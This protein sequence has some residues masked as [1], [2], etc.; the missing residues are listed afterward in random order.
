VCACVHG[1]VLSVCEHSFSRVLAH[2]FRKG[3]MSD[4]I[5]NYASPIL[6]SPC[7]QFH[8]PLD[9]RTGPPASIDRQKFG[10]VSGLNEG[11]EFHVQVVYHGA[12]LWEYSQV[13]V[14][15]RAVDLGGPL[16]RTIGTRRSRYSGA[17]HPAMALP[18]LDWPLCAC[19]ERWF[20][21]AESR[22]N[23]LMFC[24]DGI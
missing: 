22:S 13:T 9:C 8:S 20:E 1:Y 18:T 11:P 12:G 10:G 16:T 17:A 23:S 14:K 19:Q 2:A 6:T 21:C 24:L 7:H 3:Q 4:I 5:M 15:S